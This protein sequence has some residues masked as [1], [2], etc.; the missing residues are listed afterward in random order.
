MEARKFIT[1]P[2]DKAAEEALNYA[3]A[4]EDQLIEVRLTDAEFDELWQAGVFDTMNEITEAMIDYFESAEIVER[5]ELEKVLESD[6]FDK[7]AVVD[8]LAQIKVLFQEALDRGTGV[9]FF[10]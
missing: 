3:E 1:V 6:A 4:T 7:H 10:F 2:K 8:K 5:E 9:Y